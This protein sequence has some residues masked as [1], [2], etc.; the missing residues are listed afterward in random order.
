[1]MRQTVK[2]LILTML[3]H[4]LAA[5]QPSMKTDDVLPA[6][7]DLKAYRR[8]PLC[9]EKSCCSL[10]CSQA[11]D[12]LSDV[13]NLEVEFSVNACKIGCDLVANTF[14]EKPQSQRSKGIR[15]R[16][17]DF[18]VTGCTDVESNFTVSE[19]LSCTLGEAFVDP[20]VAVDVFSGVEFCCSIDGLNDVASNFLCNPPS[21]PSNDP[22]PTPTILDE[23]QNQDEDEGTEELSFSVAAYLTVSIIMVVLLVVLVAVYK[24]KMRGREKE[25]TIIL[26]PVGRNY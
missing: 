20:S 3:F 19:E 9:I 23:G 25:E 26:T 4:S 10:C 17:L 13:G 1:M 6:F 8:S 16:D 14:A 21:A 7:R 11:A 12:V 22:T 18:L 2:I 24:Y 15:A 5:S